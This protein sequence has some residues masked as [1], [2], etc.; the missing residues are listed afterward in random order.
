MLHTELQKA[1]LSRIKEIYNKR[2]VEGL[3]S[4]M[5]SF[6]RY[7]LLKRYK[8]KNAFKYN[9]RRIRFRSRVDP[10]KVIYIYIDPKRV[11][12]KA[13]AKN[14]LNRKLYR[15]V[16]DSTMYNSF[17]EHFENETPWEFTNFYKRKIKE[18]EEGKADSKERYGTKE[19]L[20]KRLNE[21][22]E[23]LEKIKE[24]GYKTQEEIYR[25]KQESEKIPLSQKPLIPAKNEIM[26]NIEKDGEIVR[27]GNGNHRF[28]IAHILN[29]NF[30]PVRVKFRRKD[31]HTL[32]KE[33][34][35]ADSLE[36]LSEKALKHLNHPDMEDVKEG[37]DKNQ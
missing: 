36:E 27:F 34:A 2:G 15:P 29:L 24:E 21:V 10:Y 31:W 11:K 17:L 25:E 26:V 14:P 3:F 8:V 6:C 37:L 19:K 12:Y 16:E 35:K 30:I 7:N 13:S 28:K 32:R 9:L 18:I 33:T 23:L 1:R 20:N 22:D 4:E 5:Y